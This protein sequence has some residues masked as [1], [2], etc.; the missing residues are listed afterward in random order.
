MGVNR[1]DTCSGHIQTSLRV[2]SDI[3]YGIHKDTISL[4]IPAI[5]RKNAG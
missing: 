4:C 3:S 5:Q 1:A 2:Q